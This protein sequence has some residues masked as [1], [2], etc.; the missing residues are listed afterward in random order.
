MSLKRDIY[1]RDFLK[2][3]SMDDFPPKRE[4]YGSLFKLTTLIYLKFF[5]KTEQENVYFLFNFI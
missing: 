5:L 3:I 1:G 4:I 2:E